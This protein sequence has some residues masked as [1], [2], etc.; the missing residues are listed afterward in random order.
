[1]SYQLLDPSL[2]ESAVI[3]NIRTS[4]ECGTFVVYKVPEKE[5][6][7]KYV[8]RLLKSSN[9]IRVVINRFPFIENTEIR[10][11][12]A[13]V[14]S[15]WACHVKEV[16]QSAIT[17]IVDSSDIENIAFVFKHDRIVEEAMPFQGSSNFFLLRYRCDNMNLPNN[18][19]S[20]PNE[21]YL[22]KK[23]SCISGTIWKDLNRVSGALRSIFSRVTE[24]L[25]HYASQY[26]KITVSPECWSY[27]TYLMISNG[28]P[29]PVNI[30]KRIVSHKMGAGLESQSIL[31]YAPAQQFRFQSNEDLDL[32]VSIFGEASFCGICRRKPKVEDKV[33]LLQPNET[34]SLI[35]GHANRLPQVGRWNNATGVDLKFC[36]ADNT[37]SLVVRYKRLLYEGLGNFE[38]TV[39]SSK[40]FKRLLKR[41]SPS[42]DVDISELNEKKA[43]ND[44]DTMIVE[45]GLEFPF[46]GEI[47]T[48]ESVNYSTGY[49]FIKN[50]GGNSAERL[51][52]QIVKQ[53]ILDY[54]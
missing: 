15:S 49:V 46:K 53:L 45:Q 17:D 19:P 43:K 20:F 26:L 51:P 27:I 16:V 41:S 36:P 35:I 5:K 14:A 39:E 25:G 12:H 47:H 10:K 29:G 8:G 28:H 4:V 23:V 21:Y 42:S 3:P 31:K 11:F 32:F 13:K 48:V 34:V 22:Y 18:F 44:D 37:L 38:V 2:D 24:K 54:L 30:K 1:M 40:R 33:R 9:N 52:I 6:E 50:V 7:S